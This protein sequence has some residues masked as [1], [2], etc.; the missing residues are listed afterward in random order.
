MVI[1]F[2]GGYDFTKADISRTPAAAGYE[3]GVA[4]GSDLKPAPAGRAPT[5]L[6]A[7]LKDPKGG[8]LD[9]IQIIKGWLDKSGK[10]QEKIYDVVWGDAERRRISNGKLTPVGNT[11][12]V[13]RATWTNTIGDPELITVWRDPDFDAT[14]RGFYYARVLEIPTPRWTAYDAAYFKIKIDDPKVPM[15]TQERAW[16]SPIWYVP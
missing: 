12:D 16:T 10:P 13:A 15:T 6:I 4:M 5:F 14:T 7:A 3:K 11:V 9:R 1:R 2:F 8:N